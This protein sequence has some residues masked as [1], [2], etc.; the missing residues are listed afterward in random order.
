[1]FVNNTVK[2]SNARHRI[3]ALLE[4][5]TEYSLAEIVLLS[6]HHYSREKKFETAYKTAMDLAVL[7]EDYR[8]GLSPIIRVFN[9]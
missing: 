6:V 8:V 2:Q 3:E 9:G 5:I 1:V 4:T 7:H